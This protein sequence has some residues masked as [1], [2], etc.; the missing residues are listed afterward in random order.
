MTTTEKRKF[1][2]DFSE[3]RKELK[4][5]LGGKGANLGEMSN[6]GL[7]V[8]PGFTI[9]TEACLLYFEHPK[10]IMDEIEPVV[11]EHLKTLEK[12]TGKKFGNKQ[13]PL[14]VSVRSGAP[15]SMPGMDIYAI[16]VCS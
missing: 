8:P 10:E 6:L 9:T 2:Y 11:I 5:L 3:G 16:R 14:L 12:T 4:N 13:D 7:N 1:V 15:M